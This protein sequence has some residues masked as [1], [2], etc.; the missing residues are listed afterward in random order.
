M[1]NQDYQNLPTQR[2]MEMADEGDG[3]ACM[4]LSA[5]YATGTTLLPMDMAKSEEWKQKANLYTYG[6][7]KKPRKK[8][9]VSAFIDDNGKPYTKPQV[10]VEKLDDLKYD[11]DRA[12]DTLKEEDKKLSETKHQLR[13]LEEPRAVNEPPKFWTGM[14]FIIL[15]AVTVLSAIWMGVFAIAFAIIVLLLRYKYVNGKRENYNQYL[16]DLDYYKKTK[17]DLLTKKAEQEN[18]VNTAKEDV[19]FYLF[20]GINSGLAI[21]FSKDFIT[22]GTRYDMVNDLKNLI[23]LRDDVYEAED[24][25]ER[26]DCQQKLYDSKLQFLY[27]YSLKGEI[28]DKEVYAIFKERMDEADDANNGNI[29][30]TDNQQEVAERREELLGD[31]AEAGDLLN[32]NRMEPI[33]DQLEV[34]RNQDT[35]SWFGFWTNESKL[36]EKT[37]QL[38]Q[39][40]SAA[41]SEYEELAK[42]NKTIDHWLNYVRA[43]AYRNVYLGVEMLNIIRDNAGGKSLTT[44]KDKSALQNINFKATK[45]SAPA[46]VASLEGSIQST[47]SNFGQAMRDKNMRKLVKENP[48]MAA[49]AMALE[50]I[51]GFLINKFEQHSQI[52]DQHSQ[53]QKELISGLSDMVDGYNAGQANALRAIE[54][55]KAIAKANKGFMAIYEPM[56]KKYIEQ[57][58]ASVDMKDLMSLA[59]ATQEY[60]HIS[61]TKL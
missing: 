37:G 13:V 38:Q 19:D 22:Q 49:G 33:L 46:N 48:K 45:I 40:Y 2:L 35:S 32:D 11:L 8:V 61:D 50:A 54:I 60:K 26:K 23:S 36:A 16:D 15:A 25:Q 53:A 39:L 43:Y 29:M 21:P 59:K 4:E 34:V 6:S 17:R 24:A 55:I 41:K 5:R 52:V 28:A 31:L 20:D 44:Q 9:R 10:V 27:K 58:S 51:G 3:K 7:K 1:T 56:R 12:T 42:V 30:R 18:A 47:L 14:F 57:Q